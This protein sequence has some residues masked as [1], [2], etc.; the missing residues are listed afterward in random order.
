MKEYAFLDENN[1]VIAIDYMDIF[2]Y[3]FPIVYRMAIQLT[4]AIGR[5]TIGQ[6][7]DGELMQ[8]V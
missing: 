8:F 1:I 4:D 2:D 6:R 3:E 5:P 7:F